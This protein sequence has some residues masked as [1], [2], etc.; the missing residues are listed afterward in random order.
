ME[1]CEFSEP[2]ASIFL[3]EDAAYAGAGSFVEMNCRFSKN[4]YILME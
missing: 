1:K 2:L 4:F 3:A